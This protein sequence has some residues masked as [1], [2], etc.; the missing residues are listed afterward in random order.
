MLTDPIDVRIL[1]PGQNWMAIGSLIANGLNGY[2]SRLPEGSTVAAVTGCPPAALGMD[3]PRLVADGWYDMA[4]TTPAWNLTM[5]REGRGPYAEPL[6]LRALAV[7]PHDDRLAFAVRRETGV[8]SLRDIAERKLPLRLSVPPREQGHPVTWVLDEILARYGFLPE[9]VE[10]WGGAVLRDRPRNQN[11][12]GG[13]PVDPT[14]DA[15]FDEAVMTMRWRRITT[16]YAMR[17]LPLDPDVLA[18]CAALGMPPGVLERGRLRG[19]DA[20]VPTIDFS[21]W[22]LYCAESMPDE[23]AYLTVRAIEEQRETI[24]GRFTGPTPAMTSP[25]DMRRAAAD[26]PVPLHPGAEAYYREAGHLA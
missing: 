13:V 7:F 26:V 1:C 15:V 8:E 12:P 5:A 9:D 6:P 22:V 2:Y 17:F 25:L 24:S 3:G 19:I 4:I 21:G 10:G 20:D 18:H 16:E 14:F 11:A 23:L